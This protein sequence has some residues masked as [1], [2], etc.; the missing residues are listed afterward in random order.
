MSMIEDARVF[1]AV[2]V[3]MGWAW[4]GKPAA[5]IGADPSRWFRLCGESQQWWRLHCDQVLTHFVVCSDGKWYHAGLAK[6]ALERWGRP[7]RGRALD[8]S[9]TDWV[10]LRAAVFK[11][12]SYRCVYCGV[13]GVP[14]HADHVIAFAAGGVSSMDNLVTA[15]GPCNSSKGAKRVEDWLK[16]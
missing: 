11:R 4:R 10:R 7:T 14:F 2:V 16:P 6:L 5:C 9:V 15:C 8:V 3:L 1:R 12:D 13:A